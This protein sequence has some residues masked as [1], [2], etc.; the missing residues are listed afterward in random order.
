MSSSANG[1][2]SGCADTLLATKAAIQGVYASSATSTIMVL[3]TAREG[4][5]AG[6]ATPVSAVRGGATVRA[7]VQLVELGALAM[8]R[9]RAQ[10][11]GQV[12]D[13]A[14]QR[15]VRRQRLGRD[16]RAAQR[17][18]RGPERC[19]RAP[20]GAMADRGN[21][22]RTSSNESTKMLAMAASIRSSVLKSLRAQYRRVLSSPD[23]DP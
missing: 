7:Y 20:Q 4:R 22:I 17:V 18:P 12:Q 13:L 23:T 14:D 10:V 6:R 5:T 19:V 15:Y 16:A 2:R 8:E 1:A 9:V 3:A 21:G 11:V